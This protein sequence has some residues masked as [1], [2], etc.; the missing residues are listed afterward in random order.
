MR[1]TQNITDGLQTT[2]VSTTRASATAT[3]DQDSFRTQWQS[4][5]RPEE[6]GAN[7]SSGQ[8]A[9]QNQVET[10]SAPPTPA[11]PATPAIPATPTAEA[12]PATPAAS[13]DNAKTKPEAD[14]ASQ[15]ALAAKASAAARQGEAESAEG[16]GHGKDKS[17]HT[18]KTGTDTTDV[19][20]TAQR[21]VSID[22]GAAAVLPVNGLPGTMQLPDQPTKASSD[23]SGAVVKKVVPGVQPMPQP[24][25]VTN[26]PV[27]PTTAGATEL[28]FAV[29]AKTKHTTGS[30]AVGTI[31]KT[32]AGVAGADGLLG[33]P[34]AGRDGIAAM[35]GVGGQGLLGGHTFGSSGRGEAQAG[36]A[37]LTAGTPH[38]IASSPTQLDVGVFDDTHGWLQIRAELG[39]GGGVNASLTSADAA[40]DLLQTAL[41]A[42]TN[43][44]GA[45]AVNVNSIALHKFDGGSS[46][47]PGSATDG[48]HPGN[49]PAHQ[50]GGEQSQQQ[51]DVQ[52]NL[53][54]TLEDAGSR[55]AAAIVDSPGGVDVAGAGTAI[56]VDAIDA[57]S[58][59]MLPWQIGFA[60]S[61]GWVNV[62]A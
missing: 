26:G 18:S 54:M 7:S 27:A 9:G 61:G 23:A 24:G 52:A 49:A 41:P 34:A 45:E 51:P 37:P 1:A 57:P 13:S 21:A 20:K 29:D 10:Q 38:L 33:N 16:I 11:A 12:T 47:M 62:S 25:P 30:A 28:A 46:G 15:A 53:A 59:Q 39:A 14:G 42:M 17:K 60:G 32:P 3:P 56:E 48:Q 8:G 35:T 22:A 2:A 19:A 58:P 44:L 43:Y 55:S 36:T 5:L 40:H 50:G 4:E 31:A 6:Q